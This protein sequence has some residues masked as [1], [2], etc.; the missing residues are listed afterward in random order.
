M[1]SLKGTLVKVVLLGLVDAF[2]VFVMITLFLSESWTILAIAAAVTL[3][4]N[5]IYLRKGG[6][7]AKYLAPG[8]FFLVI[9]QVF[10]VFTPATLP[11]PTMATGTTA[12]KRMPSR[13]SR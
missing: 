8:V 10:V 11:L 12:P 3:L 1:D 7:P 9:F 6:L 5:W 4:V 2:A 13:P